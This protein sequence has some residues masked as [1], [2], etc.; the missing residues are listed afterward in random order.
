MSATREQEL[1]AECYGYEPG[2]VQVR[3][4]RY[5]RADRLGRAA[6]A[7]LPLLGAALLSVPIPLLHLFAV[8]G[9]LIAAGVLGLRR[10]RQLEQAE[11]LR[12]PC[13][14]CAKVQAF[15]VPPRLVLP[16]TLRCPACGEFVRFLPGRSPGE[17]LR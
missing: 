14:A 9:F 13:P 12:G 3:I 11:D 6:R 10:L 2:P 15:P 1:R 17:K 4:T 7:S 8:P 16:L 5:E